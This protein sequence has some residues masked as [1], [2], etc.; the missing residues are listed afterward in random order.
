MAISPSELKYYKSIDLD[1][2]GGGI[3][4]D[5]VPTGL[6]LFYDEV[7]LPEA[8]TGSTAYRCVYVKNLSSDIL[9][10]A[11]V[12][13]HSVTPSPSTSIEMGLGTAGTNVAEQS[14]AGESIA[15]IGVT[16]FS[17]VRDSPMLLP[18]SLNSGDYHAIWLKR[19]VAPNAIGAT[20]DNV[21]LGF[22]GAQPPP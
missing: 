18:D 5:V 9:T 17:P 22:A 3:S 11:N 13:I 2:L 19:I 16:F 6:N 20:N 10:A 12:Y 1:S 14:I 7:E 21:V 4:G 8:T 15:P